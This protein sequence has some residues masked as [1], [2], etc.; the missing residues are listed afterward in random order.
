M[1]APSTNYLDGYLSQYVQKEVPL[2]GRLRIPEY[3]YLTHRVPEASW[4][5]AQ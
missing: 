3:E 2:A 1:I 4:T 5:L